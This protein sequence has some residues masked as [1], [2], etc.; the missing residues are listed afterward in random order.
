MKTKELKAQLLSDDY[1]V[2]SGEELESCGRCKEY[3][4]LFDQFTAQLLTDYEAWM[5]DEGAKNP[6]VLLQPD[7]MIKRFVEEEL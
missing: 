5:T 2:C 1:D 6:E 3:R 4:K 7:V